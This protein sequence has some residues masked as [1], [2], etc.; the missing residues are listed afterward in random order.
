MNFNDGNSGSRSAP[1]FTVGG[2]LSHLLLKIHRQ[3]QRNLPSDPEVHEDI[4]EFLSTDKYDTALRHESNNE[5]ASKRHELLTETYQ[6]LRR[7][8]NRCQYIRHNISS[9]GQEILESS[10]E[11]VATLRAQ[12][13]PN[14]DMS[15]LGSVAI[16]VKGLLEER[17]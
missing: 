17:R 6:A 12:L 9:F 16:H 15:E 3:I 1:L 2:D 13:N 5:R 10:E 8:F 7:A 14:E 11:E 4:R